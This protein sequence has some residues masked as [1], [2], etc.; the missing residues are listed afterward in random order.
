MCVFSIIDNIYT[1]LNVK[2]YTM[3]IICMEIYI[4]ISYLI[5]YILLYNNDM[6]RM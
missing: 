4:Y 6:V 3:I 5:Y 2:E 1:E